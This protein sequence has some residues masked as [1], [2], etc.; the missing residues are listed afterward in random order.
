MK[1]RIAGIL[2]FL[3]AADLSAAPLVDTVL[4]QGNEA[5]S[6]A[7]QTGPDG[8]VH[9]E[10]A[11]NDRGRGDH[12]TATWKLN[13]AG[14]PTEYE[15]RGNDYMKAPIDEHFALKN[16][17]ATWKNRAEQGDQPVTG[18]AF[19]LP[20]NPP[21]E[22]TAVLARALLKAPAH[23]LALLPAGEA[24]LVEAG[25]IALSPGKGEW[26]Q[27]RITGLG[28]SPQSIW[29]DRKGVAASVS[30]W[31]S[32]VPEGS[33]SAVPQ[34]SAAQEKTDAAWSEGI[35]RALAHQPSGDL[36]IRH[37]RLFDPRDLTVTDGT[38]V[39]V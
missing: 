5:G 34:L 4:I 12:I 10:Y 36:V 9:A 33:E 14:L 6:Q 38:T 20:M 39:L 2:V 27:Y 28:F 23:K 18:A 30:S 31:F 17:H 15:G 7:L 8:E 13:D 25:K 22:F 32:V 11:Y 21:P 26:T 1:R 35:A 16:G 19:Y 24:T 29:L 3:V 37:A